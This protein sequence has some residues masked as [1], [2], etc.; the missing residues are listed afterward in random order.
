MYDLLPAT[1]LLTAAISLTMALSAARR[2]GVAGAAELSLLMVAVGFYALTSA[3]EVMASTVG[4]KALWMRIEYFGIATTPPLFLSFTLAYV[5]LRNRLVR[6]SEIF[7]WTVSLLTILMVWTNG[8]HA[9]HW[10]GLHIDA[11]T[12]LLLYDRGPFFTVWVAAAYVVVAM[13]T[14][15]LLRSAFQN[16]R[17][18]QT[19]SALLV[20]A[21][22]CPWA[23]NLLYLSPANPYPGLDWTPIAFTLT[24]LLI[25]AAIFQ[26][27]LLS[28][29]PIARSSLFEGLPDGVIV[30]DARERVVDLNP[31]A[32][33]LMG[34]GPPPSIGTPW[35]QL[36]AQ[37]PDGFA[38]IPREGP[39]EEIPIEDKEDLRI[40]EV[41]TTPFPGER[42]RA[43][44]WIILLRDITR[45]KQAQQERE[46]LI[47]DLQEALHQVELLE[48]LLPV[49]SRCHRIRNE[50]GGWEPMESYI[51]DRSTI[52]FSHSICP[53]CSRELYPELP[54]KDEE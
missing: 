47:T 6:A 29:R 17:I 20:I 30:L 8:W 52:E 1:Y 40:L 9:L 18:F 42:V 13:G 39:P 19:Q 21:T 4:S 2:R 51:Q 25:G 23:G 27:G 3:F 32:A 49:C 35:S 37:L 14:F 36:A 16:R 33:R 11:T 7:A 24:G 46:G 10:Q 54:L 28:L 31:A 22:L 26:F 45:R 5:G 12:G 34:T 44:G 38:G 53:D 48:G 41:T 43:E 50:G 15:L